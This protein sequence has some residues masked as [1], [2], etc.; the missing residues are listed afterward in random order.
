M[1]KWH[2]TWNDIKIDKFNGSTEAAIFLKV[3]YLITN[4]AS[5]ATTLKMKQWESF[6]R[7]FKNF[8][9]S[10]WNRERNENKKELIDSVTTN[11]KGY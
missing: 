2:H 5:V 6:R 1:Y 10:Y 8:Y 7:S 4:L 3:V 11:I 9:S